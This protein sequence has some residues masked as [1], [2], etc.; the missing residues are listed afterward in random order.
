MFCFSCLGIPNGRECN[1]V[2]AYLNTVAGRAACEAK[3]CDRSTCDAIRNNYDVL[4]SAFKAAPTIRRTDGTDAFRQ[5][6]PQ[7][8]STTYQVSPADREKLQRAIPQQ[9]QSEEHAQ[10]AS[11][12]DQASEQS[13]HHHHQPGMCHVCIEILQ[14]S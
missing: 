10:Q 1:C 6:D 12:A 11:A 5:R 14:H 3:D 4:L 13:E 9:T 7:V 8:Y 2:T